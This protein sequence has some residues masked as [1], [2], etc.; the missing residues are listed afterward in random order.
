MTRREF[1]KWVSEM[2]CPLCCAPLELEEA[3]TC[4]CS[5]SWYYDAVCT[6]CSFAYKDVLSISGQ[7]TGEDIQEDFDDLVK[8]MNKRCE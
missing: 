2:S 4:G 1:E 6:K 7:T 3:Y 8:A 5:S